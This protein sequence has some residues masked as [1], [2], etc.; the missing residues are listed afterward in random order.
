M[1]FK[2]QGGPF[3]CPHYTAQDR[4]IGVEAARDSSYGQIEFL[5]CGW[6]T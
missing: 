5:H 2:A 4:M 3:N 1:V 6:S